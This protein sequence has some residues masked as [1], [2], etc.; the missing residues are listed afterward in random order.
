MSRVILSRTGVLSVDGSCMHTEP[1]KNK[2]DLCLHIIQ[3]HECAKNFVDR[4]N[5]SEF[6]LPTEISN[7]CLLEGHKCDYILLDEMIFKYNKFSKEDRNLINDMFSRA[8]YASALCHANKVSD[9]VSCG[10]NH[11][12]S[13]NEQVSYYSYCSS[14]LFK[15]VYKTNKAGKIIESVDSGNKYFLYEN[16]DSYSRGTKDAKYVEDWSNNYCP[17][18]SKNYIFRDL[19]ETH[20]EVT[21]FNGERYL[22]IHEGDKFIN[23]YRTGTILEYNIPLQ[24]GEMAFNA[25]TPSNEG[26]FDVTVQDRYGNYATVN[27]TGIT[28]QDLKK[29]VSIKSF[30]D[31]LFATQKLIENKGVIIPRSKNWSIKRGIESLSWIEQGFKPEEVTLRINGTSGLNYNKNRF[32]ITGTKG[33]KPVAIHY[34]YDGNDI[35]TYVADLNDFLQYDVAPGADDSAYAD[36]LREVHLQAT[37][38]KSY[39]LGVSTKGRS[40]IGRPVKFVQA[41]V[42]NEDVQVTDI[43][44]KVDQGDLVQ[45]KFRKNK[46][47]KDEDKEQILLGSLI[48]ND[49]LNLRGF[50][51]DNSNGLYHN[52]DYYITESGKVVHKSKLNESAITMQDV[53][54]FPDW[55]IEE[56]TNDANSV[57]SWYC[58]DCHSFFKEPRYDKVDMFDYQGVA[59]DFPG[60]H[61][62]QD[63]PKC[64]VC[65][66]ENVKEKSVWQDDIIDAIVNDQAACEEVYKKLDKD[67]PDIVGEYYRRDGT[68]HC[69]ILTDEPDLAWETIKELL[70][71]F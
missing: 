40:H 50:V 53:K 48:E 38:I 26:S 37:P 5:N 19:D 44:P 32:V 21:S 18:Q 47:K 63:M 28:E 45:I 56:F 30:E 9:V 31:R 42:Q 20:Q 4:Y 23:S 13:L 62:Y 25:Y 54:N 16:A 27:I 60:H 14:L 10:E 29:I 59:G 64:P 24:K 7:A 71:D 22:V 46:K 70:G 6:Y 52:G 49:L 17:T 8:A 67:H 68:H 33:G 66:S 2:D 1:F 51:K 43:A 12:L 58:E 35:N 41:K 15:N 65:G 3:L 61:S 57:S 36:F 34:S 39:P 55:M 69:D 11:E